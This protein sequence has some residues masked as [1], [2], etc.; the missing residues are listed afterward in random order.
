MK[1]IT[2]QF[3]LQSLHVFWLQLVHY[4]LAGRLDA[5]IFYFESPGQNQIF[6]KFSSPV[7]T[8]SGKPSLTKVSVEQCATICYGQFEQCQCCNGFK[9][10]ND[11]TCYLQNYKGLSQDSTTESEEGYQSFQIF[12]E[13]TVLE[14]YG[15]ILNISVSVDMTAPLWYIQP[16]SYRFGYSTLGW[17]VMPL[18][19]GKT[20]NNIDGFDQL[21]GLTPLQCAKECNKVNNQNSQSDQQC[22][23]FMYNPFQGGSCFLKSGCSGPKDIDRSSSGGNDDWQF[24]WREDVRGIQQRCFCP[25]GTGHYC[26][27]CQHGEES[28]EEW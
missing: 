13:S 10:G 17:G 23:G 19:D 5:P 25:C 7:Q 21:A 22:D 20:I 15:G 2:N 8:V 11:G 4:T 3:S 16:K 28:C 9:Y 14:G 6:T 24:Y 1:I 18:F 26:L 27:L 12:G